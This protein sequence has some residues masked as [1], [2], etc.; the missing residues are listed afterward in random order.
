MTCGPSSRADRRPHGSPRGVT[1]SHALS[2]YIGLP[3]PSAIRRLA[4]ALRLPLWHE[5]QALAQRSAI[6]RHPLWHCSPLDAAGLP[7][8]LV[9]GMGSTP[10]LLRPLHDLLQRLNCQV[11]APSVRLGIG[12]GEATTRVVE[13][14]LV[15]HVDTAARPAVIIGHSRGGQFARAVAVRRPHLIRGLITLGSPLTD[16]FAVHPLLRVPVA[17]LSVAGALGIP[18]LLRPTCLWGSCCAQLRA[19]LAGP[20]P[21]M[22]R[23]LSV[24]SRVDTIVDWR[25]TRDP[26][27]RHHEVHT[28]H[29]GLIWDPTSI[30]VIVDELAH[31]VGGPVSHTP[32][33]AP[34]VPGPTAA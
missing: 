18:G 20:F 8:L 19:D 22:V 1:D 34:P 13:D 25:S 24:H 16:L 17:A 11:V 15:R 4:A 12:C 21:A 14:A 7:V 9:G 23:F 6:E 5:A 31:S 26:A 3:R 28:S 30:A 32:R 33:P 2:D 10:Q 29:G 27:A